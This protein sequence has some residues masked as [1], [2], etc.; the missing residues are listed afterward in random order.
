LGGWAT[1]RGDAQELCKYPHGWG[2]AAS[3]TIELYA[4]IPYRWDMTLTPFWQV[5]KISYLRQLGK[6]LAIKKTW[7]ESSLPEA[8]E[9]PRN[10]VELE[11]FKRKYQ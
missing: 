2:F 3:T 8:G 10:L 5:L 7:L 6:K 1:S 11:E 4:P 9:P